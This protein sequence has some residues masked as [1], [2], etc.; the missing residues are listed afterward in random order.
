MLPGSPVDVR[1]RCYL[2]GICLREGGE[3][4]SRVSCGTYQMCA[5]KQPYDPKE[6]HDPAH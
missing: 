3:C 4:L 6:H 5:Q 2:C 1:P